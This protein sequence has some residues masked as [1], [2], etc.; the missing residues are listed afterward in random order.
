ML[1]KLTAVLV[2]YI[3]CNPITLGPFL[4]WVHSTVQF[5][6]TGVLGSIP[7]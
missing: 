4:E 2:L 1:V 5:R 7:E 3:G 6:K